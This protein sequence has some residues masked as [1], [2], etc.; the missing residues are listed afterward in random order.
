MPMLNKS[1]TLTGTVPVCP[2][3]QAGKN[4]PCR[5]IPGRARKD[6]LSLP[7][8]PDLSPGNDTPPGPLWAL[9]YLDTPLIPDDTPV[10]E[11]RQRSLLPSGFRRHITD[12]RHTASFGS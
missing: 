9:N 8:W 6:T 10:T 4:E 5:L 2:W 11:K 12:L 7:A 1:K 3:P